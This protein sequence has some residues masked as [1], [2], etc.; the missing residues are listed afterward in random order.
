MPL[1]LDVQGGQNSAEK[2][3]RK[4]FP[5]SEEKHT[6]RLFFTPMV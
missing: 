3:E 1:W 4:D 5:G 6:G 2:Q